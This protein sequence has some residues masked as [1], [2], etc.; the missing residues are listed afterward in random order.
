MTTMVCFQAAGAAYCLP[1]QAAR[2]VRTTADLV[3]LPDPAA[4]VA[5]IIP[6][7]PPLTVISPLENDGRHILVI[8]AN[9]KTFGLLVDVV[10][11]IRQVESADIRPAPKGQGRPLVA[12]TF[13]TDGHLVFVADPTALAERL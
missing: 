1:L 13:D 4:D 7:D 2:S 9:G 10:T 12:G 5:G 11:G 6:G 3:S 8:E